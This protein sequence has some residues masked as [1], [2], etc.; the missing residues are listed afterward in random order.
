MIAEYRRILKNPSDEKIKKC[1][2]FHSLHKIYQAKDVNGVRAAL[3]SNNSNE[4]D[5]RFLDQVDFDDNLFNI[6]NNNKFNDNSTQHSSG[7][8]DKEDEDEE[9]F[10]YAMSPS[11]FNLS[12]LFHNSHNSNSFLDKN[13]AKKFNNNSITRQDSLT[14]S[15]NGIDSADNHSQNSLSEQQPFVPY[16]KRKSNFE[17][18]DDNYYHHNLQQ[19]KRK[20][21]NLDINQDDELSYNFTNIDLIDKMFDY[22]AECNHAMLEW[23][24]LEQIRLQQDA[25]RKK[26][27][28]E[29]EDR[30]EKHFVE[31]LISVQNTFINFIKK[32]ESEKQNVSL[33]N[34][35][36]E[37]DTVDASSSI[38]KNGQQKQQEQ[39]RNL[40]YE[41]VQPEGI[42]DAGDQD[43]FDIG[44][45][46]SN[47]D[48][49][50][51]LHEEI[52]ESFN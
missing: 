6:N 39:Q 14:N 49:T 20:K 22:L 13:V 16:L 2:F 21:M 26:E 46:S 45:S 9:V 52:V 25:L 30:K 50:N 36:S 33:A 5:Y 37:D 51:V 38:L 32:N 24:K 19:Q 1:S 41:I 11:N 43:E 17:L 34:F 42:I 4:D 18:N 35:C 15:W 12:S 44:S 28:M 48:F 40:E 31:A 3:I 7:L 8:E 27:E 23:V 10:T 29:N 47:Y